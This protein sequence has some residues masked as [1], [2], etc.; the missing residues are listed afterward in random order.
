MIPRA[1]SPATSETDRDAPERDAGQEV[2]RSVDRVDHPDRGGRRVARPAFLAEKAVG[3][4][5]AGQALDNEVLAGAVRFADQI[6]RALAV[7]AQR[8]AA[9]EVPGGEATGF[10]DHVLRGTQPVV[11]LGGRQRSP[12]RPLRSTMRARN[13]TSSPEIV[14]DKSPGDPLYDPR[15]DVAAA[16]PGFGQRLRRWQVHADRAPGVVQRLRVVRVEHVELDRDR[17]GAARP[18]HPDDVGVAGVGDG[19]GAQVRVA[20]DGALQDDVVEADHDDPVGGSRRIEQ[21]GDTVDREVGAL[22]LLDLEHEA[23]VRALRPVERLCE[24][25]DA[26]PG[27]ARVEARPRI[28]TADALDVEVGRVA[29]AVGR[30]VEREVVQDD[31]LAVG[32]QNDVDLDGGRARNP[33]RPQ[34]PGGCSPG[35]AGCSRDGRRRGPGR[36]RWQGS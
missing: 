25:R 10:A 22:G 23:H 7:D 3:R 12:P 30:A 36:P 13:G 16:T 1:S 21:G 9:G 6:L 4:E 15:D 2:V 33:L 17:A 20:L 11:E 5:P 18:Q 34:A 32:G 35:S 26:G 29:V 24:R 31:G 8:L 19:L 27:K 14:V 28:E